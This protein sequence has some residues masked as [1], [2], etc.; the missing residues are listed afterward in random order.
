MAQNID[1]SIAA[2]KD[3]EAELGRR[4]EEIRLSQNR[5]Q[6]QIAEEAGVSRRTIT[7]LENGGGVSLDTFIRVMR[8]LGVVD[9][10]QLLLPDPT[11]RPIDRVRFKGRERK[12]ITGHNTERLSHERS[13]STSLPS[14]AMF[15]LPVDFWAD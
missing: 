11:I 9:R 15:L 10:F 5:N 8:A 3:I 13:T 12:H 6:S 14:N 4:L 1:Y 2:P 7:R